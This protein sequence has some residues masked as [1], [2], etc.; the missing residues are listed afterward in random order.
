MAKVKGIYKRGKKYWIMYAG[1]DGKTVFESTKSEKFEDAKTILIDRR[2]A[3]KDGHQPEVKKIANC[4]FNDL[5][6]EYKRWV[7]G[8][9]ASAEVKGYIIGKLQDR[10][11]NIPLRRFNT[12]I[13]EQLQTD[14]IGKEF[15][16]GYINKVLGVLKAMFTKAVDWE[17]VELETLK[18]VRKVKQ[19]PETGRLRYLES[20]EQCQALINACDSH[21]RPVVITALNT[22]LRKGNILSLKWASVD[23]RNGFI[24]IPKTKNNERLEVPINETLRATLEGLPRRIDGGYVFYDPKTDKPYKDVKRSFGSALGRAKIADFH[25]HDLRHTFASHLVMAGVD[26]TS[27]KELLGHKDIKM[28]LRYAHLAPSHKVK[29]VNILDGILGNSP[30][31]QKLDNQGVAI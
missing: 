25:F 30:T 29:A 15:K 21:L 11:G 19:L 14:L 24:L 18:R 23:L 22:G 1:L 13:V 27:V 26:L 20:K 9:H 6:K 2:K 4:F 28:T 10:F 17:M 7:N 8:R 31:L 16:N 3:I 5:V 12:M